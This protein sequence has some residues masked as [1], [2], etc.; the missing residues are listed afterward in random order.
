M[1][2]LNFLWT[3]QAKIKVIET[4]A[5][6]DRIVALVQKAKHVSRRSF[7]GKKMK[8]KGDNVFR[9]NEVLSVC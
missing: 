1:I 2:E 3:K 7:S 4:R 8:K 5:I 9:C 6:T